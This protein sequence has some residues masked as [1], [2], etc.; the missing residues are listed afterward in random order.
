MYKV[1]GTINHEVEDC[2]PTLQV[3]EMTSDE[4]LFS[5]ILRKL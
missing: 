3:R 4:Y 5:V 2:H 1:W